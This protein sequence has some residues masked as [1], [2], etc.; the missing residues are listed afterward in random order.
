MAKAKKKLLPKDFEQLL[1]NGD[2]GAIKAVF[3]TCDVDA[4]GG[5]SKQTALAFNALSDD[6]VRW[7]VEQGASISATDNYGETPLHSR[8]GDWHGRIGIL[9]DLGANV[10]AG[11][12]ERCTA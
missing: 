12:G 3:E 2:A 10:N 1:K 8:A 7:L 5:Y 9:L 4:R 11:E 6:L